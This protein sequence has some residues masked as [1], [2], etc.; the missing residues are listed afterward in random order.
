MSEAKTV[1]SIRLLCS[2][3][4]RIDDA[5]G[6]IRIGL[7]DRVQNVH[8]G[9]ALPCGSTAFKCELLVK[10]TPFVAA[11]DFSGPCVHGPKGARFIYLS[12]KRPDHA[13]TSWLWRVKIP[14]SR[15]DWEMI[16]GCE[17]LQADITGRKPHT[18]AAIAWQRIARS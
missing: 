6:P 15:L 13:D 4:P 7:Q 14:L 10:G 1:L 5:D 11:P 9:R 18:S 17:G 3:L 16:N 12:W 8:R 2:S